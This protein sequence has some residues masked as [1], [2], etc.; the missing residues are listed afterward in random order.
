MKLL[1]VS[2]TLVQSP[3]TITLKKGW[4]GGLYLETNDPYI[5]S[6]KNIHLGLKGNELI[7]GAY[8]KGCVPFM[9]SWEKALLQEALMSQA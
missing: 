9:T 4:D 7:F 6:H 5:A 8:P 3:N 1:M 2:I